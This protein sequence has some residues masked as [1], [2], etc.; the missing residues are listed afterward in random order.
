ML[1]KKDF[2]LITHLRQDGRLTL[3]DLSRKTKIPVSTIFDRI[4]RTEQG[5]VKKTVAVIDFHKLGF[6]VTA[7]IM[8]K[9][10][11]EKERLEYYLMK[12]IN[13]NTIYKV[14]NGFDY[15]VEVIFTN[16]SQLERFLEH[17]EIKFGLK[18][19]EVHY[20]LEEIKKEEFLNN[21]KT[22]N[23]LVESNM[24]EHTSTKEEK[25]LNSPIQD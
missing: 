3:T 9:S 2:L 22:L 14:N 17:I 24:V 4:K 1:K 21:P 16:M 10:K 20:L 7:H 11:N 23:L 15:I 6:N 8:M 18:R 25:T 12:N 5:Y 13:V 19:L